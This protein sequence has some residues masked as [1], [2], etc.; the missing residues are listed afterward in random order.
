[1]SPKEL[2]SSPKVKRP[3]NLGSSVPHG[4]EIAVWA[5]VSR[6]PRQGCFINIASIVLNNFPKR[7]P[8][9]V[10]VQGRVDGGRSACKCKGLS[11]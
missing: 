8:T 2:W 4:L 6:G 3:F 1:M 9:G 11:T 7:H 10:E 5:L